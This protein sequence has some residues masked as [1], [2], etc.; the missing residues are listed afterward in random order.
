M[1]GIPQQVL[2]AVLDEIAAVDE[3]KFQIPIGIGVREALVDRRGRSRGAA[4]Q[5]RE[6]D[7]RRG[8]RRGRQTDERAGACAGRQQSQNSLHFFLPRN[9][10]TEACGCCR[11]RPARSTRSAPLPAVHSRHHATVLKITQAKNAICTI[12][13]G[14]KIVAGRSL[15]RKSRGLPS[16][17][18]RSLVS[19][20]TPCT[21]TPP[22]VHA[23][24]QSPRWKEAFSSPCKAA[25]LG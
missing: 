19:I 4:V 6:R 21:S 2:V 8:L 24:R 15:I 3:L 12:T 18:S 7:V 10:S 20:V 17:S 9:S 13:S 25:S 22:V 11:L 1:T 16:T 14:Q 5:A 23:G